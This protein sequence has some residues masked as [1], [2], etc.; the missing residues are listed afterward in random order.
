MKIIVTGNPVDGF[1][2]YG[3]PFESLDDNTADYFEGD[4]RVAELEPIENSEEESWSRH[5]PFR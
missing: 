3:P 5:A 1:Q 2:F 4:W